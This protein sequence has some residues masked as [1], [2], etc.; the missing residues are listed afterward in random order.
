MYIIVCTCIHTL[1]ESHYFFYKTFMELLHLF[2]SL[3]APAVASN[4]TVFD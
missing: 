3:K 1:L 4:R 2:L